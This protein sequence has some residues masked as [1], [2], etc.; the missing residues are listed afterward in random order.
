MSNVQLKKFIFFNKNESYL[1]FEKLKIN[2]FDLKFEK[3]KKNLKFLFPAE[4]KG[5]QFVYFI[6]F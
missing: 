5:Y 6:S 3:F 4:K 2:L 1:F